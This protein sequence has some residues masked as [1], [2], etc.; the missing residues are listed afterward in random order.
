MVCKCRSKAGRGSRVRTAPFLILGRAS[1]SFQQTRRDRIGSY[2][3]DHRR[4]AGSS[5][6]H[7]SSRARPARRD[8]RPF[9]C[10]ALQ[11]P[12]PPSLQRPIRGSVALS[13]APGPAGGRERVEMSPAGYEFGPTMGEL[14]PNSLD[15]SG[16]SRYSCCCTRG[17]NLHSGAKYPN[18]S[19]GTRSDFPKCR[20]R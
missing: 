3:A 18:D 13:L 6:A 8:R 19:N 9:D 20:R 16:K 4:L 15:V 17:R 14:G 5:P 2:A 7:G 10:G 12:Q 11:P 1:S